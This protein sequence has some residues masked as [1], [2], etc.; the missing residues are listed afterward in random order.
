MSNCLKCDNKLEGR[1]H[2]FCS[3]DCNRRYNFDKYG[4]HEYNKKLRS[5]S[6]RAYLSRLRSVTNR[7]D[8]LSLDFLVNLYEKQKGLCSITNHPMTFIQPGNNQKVSTNMS[9]DRIDSSL[10][11]IE[12]NVRLVCY[13]ANIMKLDGT[14]QELR[15]WCKKIL[16]VS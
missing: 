8:T 7:K 10:G 2:K 16:R 13:R 6:P 9:I 3:I 11:Y 4:G 12:D 15:D 1:Q 5:A 14:D